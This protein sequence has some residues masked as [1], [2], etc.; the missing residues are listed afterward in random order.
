MNSEQS[1]HIPHIYLQ[2]GKLSDF[3]EFKHTVNFRNSND[4]K[5]CQELIRRKMNGSGGTAFS[6]HVDHLQMAEG[7]YAGTPVRVVKCNV[8][9]DAFFVHFVNKKVGRQQIRAH[10]MMYLPG[11]RGANSKEAVTFDDD[12]EFVA[13]YLGVVSGKGSYSIIVQLQKGKFFLDQPRS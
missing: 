1:R 3:G 10:D 8:F 5:C 7:M 11:L 2:L 12:L 9:D 13:L 4:A 6:I